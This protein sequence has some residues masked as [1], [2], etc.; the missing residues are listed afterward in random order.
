MA[1]GATRIPLVQSPTRARWYSS[2]RHQTPRL[3]MQAFVRQATTLYPC[4]TELSTR[5]VQPRLAYSSHHCLSEQQPDISAKIAAGDRL[6]GDTMFGSERDEL[7][8]GDDP[9]CEWLV[10]TG[11]R[12]DNTAFNVNQRKVGRVCCFN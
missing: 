12:L 8:V 3:Y 9:V 10:S 4:Q 6:A 7:P 1:S 2:A 11:Q 5:K